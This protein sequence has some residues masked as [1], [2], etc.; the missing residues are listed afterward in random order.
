MDTTPATRPKPA[1]PLRPPR[2]DDE[3]FTIG[4]VYDISEV[5]AR[6][7]YPPLAAGNDFLRFSNTLFAAI[8]QEN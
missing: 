5:L 2:H 1:Y 3:R 7:G 4:L 6:H 8:Y